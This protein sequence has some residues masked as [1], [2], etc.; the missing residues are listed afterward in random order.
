MSQKFYRI[1][2]LILV[3]VLVFTSMPLVKK[4]LYGQK[5]QKN[6]YENVIVSTK[7]NGNVEVVNTV[8]DT[9]LK[10]KYTKDKDKYTLYRDDVAY[11]LATTQY[12]ENLLIDLDASKAIQQEGTVVGQFAIAIPL[13]LWT[14]VLIEAAQ[15]TI[16]AAV[17][18]VGTYTI[19][20]SVDSIAKTIENTKVEEKV[21]AKEV[22][23][24]DTKKNKAYY[25]AA[26]VGGVVAINREITFEE[27]VIRL[28]AGKDV[29]A[30]NKMA[31]STVAVAAT[32]PGKKT[33]HHLAHDVGEGFYPHFHPGG[34][35]WIVNPKNA[36]HCWYGATP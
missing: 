3:V 28:S 18:V 20:Y 10:V 30:T 29:F 9:T 23:K 25:S 11:D 15:I 16:A 2:V 13:I 4:H 31:A 6:N 36:P 27:A 1:T 12:G 21:V 8:S 7:G 35:K 33:I 5:V 32:V 24:E 34:R 17:A 19:W 14:P 22:A 26:L